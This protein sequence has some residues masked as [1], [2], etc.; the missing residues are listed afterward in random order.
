MQS[1][2]KRYPLHSLMDTVA[3]MLRETAANVVMPIFGRREADPQEKSSGEWVTEADRAAPSTG[4][5]G[6]R[7]SCRWRRSSARGPTDLATPTHFE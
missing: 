6:P 5:T 7:I 1:A 3:E 2:M 4:R